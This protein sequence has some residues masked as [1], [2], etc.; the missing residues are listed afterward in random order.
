MPIDPGMKLV[1]DQLFENPHLHNAVISSASPPSLAKSNGLAGL[2]YLLL[3]LYRV[4]HTVSTSSTSSTGSTN[5]K[6]IWLIDEWTNE[7]KE[8]KSDHGKIKPIDPG[9]ALVGDQ[10]FENPTCIADP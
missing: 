3:L 10:L 5:P 8:N 6:S 2:H 7:S 1:G 4:P 9:M